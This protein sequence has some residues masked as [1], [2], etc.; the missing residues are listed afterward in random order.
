MRV[1]I[2]LIL[3]GFLAS[4]SLPRE[5]QYGDKMMTK[6]KFDRVIKRYTRDFVREMSDEDARIFLNLDIVYDT[7]KN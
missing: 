5:Y 1:I 2:F 4:C 3:V 7:T 6:R